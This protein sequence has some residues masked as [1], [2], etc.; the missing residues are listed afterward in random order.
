VKAEDINDHFE[1]KAEIMDT[2]VQ[3]PSFSST[4]VSGLGHAKLA[5]Q[6]SGPATSSDSTTAEV[7]P[8]SSKDSHME[9][10]TPNDP[11]GASIVGGS[12]DVPDSSNS[13]PLDLDDSTPPESTRR[14]A[15]PPPPQTSRTGS[16]LS[17]LPPVFEDDDPF[18]D[19]LST[20]SSEVSAMSDTTCPS[21]DGSPPSIAVDGDGDRAR[22]PSAGKE[23]P[24][25]AEPQPQPFLVISGKAEGRLPAEKA[26]GPPKLVEAARL[27]ELIKD[28]D[29]WLR[30][31][32][33]GTA[34]QFVKD[35]EKQVRLVNCRSEV[36]L[37]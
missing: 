10:S 29:K 9:R 24:A 1:A 31:P 14:Q 8:L 22:S 20:T 15:A 5:R 30:A 26:K 36:I 19:M 33:T 21:D 27:N 11:T 18:S 28:L 6:S 7:L 3:S 23:T 17:P 37:Y 16:P 25:I 32:N 2:R 35:M 34:A 12:T 4:L 13:L